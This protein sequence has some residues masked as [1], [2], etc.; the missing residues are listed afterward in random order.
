MQGVKK[1]WIFGTVSKENC[2]MDVFYGIDYHSYL[3]TRRVGITAWD[4]E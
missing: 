3:G 4:L 2:V 1:G